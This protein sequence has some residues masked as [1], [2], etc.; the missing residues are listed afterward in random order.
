MKTY[1]EIS[2]PSTGRIITNQVVNLLSTIQSACGKKRIAS[3]KKAIILLVL[4]LFCCALLLG[5][6]LFSLI[7]ISFFIISLVMVINEFIQY[8]R[9]IREMEWRGTRESLYRIVPLWIC[10]LLGNI[11]AWKQ[12]FPCRFIAGFANIWTKKTYLNKWILSDYRVLREQLFTNGF[13]YL[14]RIISDG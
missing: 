1:I 14:W 10:C 5:C 9:F 8:I 7:I 11:V 4:L 13:W 2:R 6:S 12:Y 3:K